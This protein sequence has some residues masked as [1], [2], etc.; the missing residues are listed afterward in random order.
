MF[1]IILCT[2]AVLLSLMAHRL[3]GV[4][5]QT[6]LPIHESKVKDFKG[7]CQATWLNLSSIDLRCYT[8]RE[9]VAT[10][11]FRKVKDKKF[12]G[13]NIQ[14]GREFHGMLTGDGIVIST[15]GIYR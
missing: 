13:L 10:G 11:F 5:R 9:A 4:A 8:P 12:L 6:K 7:P 2:I 14:T 1:Y 15:E 3:I